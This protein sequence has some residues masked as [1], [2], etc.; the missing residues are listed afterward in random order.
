LGFGAGLGLA[1]VEV[2]AQG[3][4]L[5]R[6]LGGGAGGGGKLGFGWDFWLWHGFFKP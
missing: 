3:G 5:T 6:G 2:G 4:G 1:P